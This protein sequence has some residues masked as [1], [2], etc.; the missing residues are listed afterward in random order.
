MLKSATDGLVAASFV[1]DVEVDLLHGAI[2]GPPVVEAAVVDPEVSV[3]EALH[4]AVGNGCPNS[5][6]TS[7]DNV[8]KIV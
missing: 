6:P 2:V 5:R 7:Q 4:D 8:L 3:A 1:V